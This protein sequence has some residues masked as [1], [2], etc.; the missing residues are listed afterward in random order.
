VGAK[1]KFNDHGWVTGIVRYLSAGHELPS[2][3]RP[4]ATDSRVNGGFP[5]LVINKSNQMQRLF[6]LDLFYSILIEI[7]MYAYEKNDKV[8]IDLCNLFH[9][10]SLGL[11]VEDNGKQ[12]YDDF[13]ERVDRHGMT[14]W[15]NSNMENYKSFVSNADISVEPGYHNIILYSI[16][17]AITEIMD[18][19]LKIQDKASYR[20]CKMIHDVP[21]DLMA[22]R[23][24][25]EAF[26]RF[27]VKLEA[28]GMHK[29]LMKL[30]DDF[31][32]ALPR[33][34]SVAFPDN[35]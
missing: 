20:L 7:R 15:L 28:D 27:I 23:D 16:H 1:C 29:L 24:G 11:I 21:L 31:F 8:S 19:A 12:A 34:R 32:A 22:N 2:R 14:N 25:K 9:N 10:I 4:P 6:L 17:V 33:Y 18:R 35:G 30:F 5:D 3:G 26:S 13:I